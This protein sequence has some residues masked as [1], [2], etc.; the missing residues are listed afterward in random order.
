MTVTLHTESGEDDFVTIS[1]KNCNVRDFP[2]VSGDI[3]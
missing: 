1:T 3:Q 2:W